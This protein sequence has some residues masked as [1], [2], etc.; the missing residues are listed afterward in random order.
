M[1]A[2][3]ADAQIAVVPTNG[4]VETL[5]RF[6]DEGGVKLG[7]LSSDVASAYA[8]AALRGFAEAQQLIAPL[9]VIAALGDEQFHF[10]V[11][12]DA[13]FQSF[14]DIRDARINVGPINGSTALSLGHFYRLFFG[15]PISDARLSFLSHEDALARLVTDRSIDVVAILA[16][17]PAKLLAEMKPEARQYVKFL[18]PGKIPAE[19]AHTLDEY[20]AARLL[21]ASYPNLLNEDIDSYSVRLLLV[22][23]ERAPVE[24]D[25]VLA[26]FSRAL[27]K[28]IPRFPAEGLANWLGVRPE[29]PDLG[30]GWHY[31]SPVVRNEIAACAAGNLAT[32]A[33][34][35]ACT[36]NERILG[37]CR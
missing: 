32:R 36:V 17:Q 9:R 3:D 37:V 35:A 28:N 24:N 27:C 12:S 22:A 20:R 1:I 34:S 6:R 10:V 31:A 15:A 5:M 19:H 23:H 8:D 11:R 25:A 16:V 14:A 26:T 4:S 30:R 29:L 33:A 7:F 13:T 18:K 21:A 2:R